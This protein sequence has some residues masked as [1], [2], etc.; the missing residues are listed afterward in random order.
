MITILKIQEGIYEKWILCKEYQG[1]LYGIVNMEINEQSQPTFGQIIFTVYSTQ[2]GG[3]R[4]PN[5]KMEI[6]TA[7]TNQHQEDHE[8]ER[9]G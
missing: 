8:L 7:I 9:R 1:S 5:V 6:K 2:R 4:N 3:N